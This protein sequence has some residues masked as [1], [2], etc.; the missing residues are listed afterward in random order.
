MKKIEWV[1]RTPSR[2]APNITSLDCVVDNLYFATIT[3]VRESP[4]PMQYF[5]KFQSAPAVTFGITSLRAGMD[6]VEA[7][8]GPA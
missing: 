8:I 1:I 7:R 3:Q 5:V 2:D 4:K 6:M